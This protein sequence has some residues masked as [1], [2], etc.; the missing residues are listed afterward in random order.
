MLKKQNIPLIDADEVVYSLYKNTSPIL[1]HIQA[2]FKTPITDEDGHID[3]NKI[4]A[5]IK[6]DASL[7][8]KLEEIVHPAV[9]TFIKVWLEKQNK[10]G[11]KS[12]VLSVPLMFDAGFDKLCDVILCCNTSNETRK[13]RFMQRPH[14]TEEKWQLI[15]QKQ[16]SLEDYLTKSDYNIPTDTSLENT[17]QVLQE[18]LNKV[19]LIKT[20][21][22]EKKWQHKA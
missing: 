11:E 21:A 2:L 12:T 5:E 10:K 3:R 13:E 8:Q 17:Q 1:K 14:S 16:M 22:F 19:N 20:K 7:L 9:R 6:K 15:T 4:A 18:T